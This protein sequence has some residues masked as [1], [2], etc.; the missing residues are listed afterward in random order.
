MGD[1][2]PFIDPRTTTGRKRGAPERLGSWLEQEDEAGGAGAAPQKKGG[3]HVQ[4][5]KTRHT[6]LDKTA[7]PPGL[8]GSEEGVAVWTA[9][10]RMMGRNPRTKEDE[11]VRGAWKVSWVPRPATGRGTGNKCGD[12]YIFSPADALG[13]KT[14]KIR[15]VRMHSAR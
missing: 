6:F 12:I 9:A 10:A 7:I 13:D 11:I 3:A 4:R 14:I 1:I 8:A 15:S 5:H 2:V